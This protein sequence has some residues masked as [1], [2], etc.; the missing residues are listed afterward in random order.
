MNV[1]IKPVPMTVF[2]PPPVT[3]NKAA[4]DALVRQPS[5]TVLAYQDICDVAGI[6][7]RVSSSDLERRIH[8]VAEG[9]HAR[10]S[11]DSTRLAVQLNDF[12]PEPRSALR[13]LEILAYGFN[14]YAAREAVCGR[15]LFMP[16]APRGRR[17]SGTALTSAEKMWRYRQKR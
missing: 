17:R 2:I 9:R 13:V 8:V 5:E 3:L 4:W 11:A 12:R 6:P 7:S 10:L 1:K 15:G 14:D 16:T